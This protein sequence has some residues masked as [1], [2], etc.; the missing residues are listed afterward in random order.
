MRRLKYYTE[1][2]TIMESGITGVAKLKTLTK[3]K[4]LGH[5]GLGCAMFLGLFFAGTMTPLSAEE[6]TMLLTAMAKETDALAEN[7]DP[8]FIA[9]HNTS[10]ALPMFIPVFGVAWG[11]FAGYQTGLL[12][13]AMANEIEG[14]EGWMGLSL[15]ITPVGILELAAYALA[16]SRSWLW[17][18]I[19]LKKKYRTRENLKAMIRP[20]IIEAIIVVALLFVGGYVEMWM[21]NEFG[22]ESLTLLDKYR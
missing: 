17:G 4:R 21:I 2:V 7:I 13:S 5:F 6:S 8:I 1:P 18:R 22:S 20:T 15:F 3:K 11:D 19:L 9:V 12:I 14:F 10:I 16:I